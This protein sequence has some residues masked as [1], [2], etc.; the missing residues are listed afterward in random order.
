[1]KQNFGL[2]QAVAFKRQAYYWFTTGMPSFERLL[3][4]HEGRASDLDTKQVSPKEYPD[5]L[6]VRD[7]QQILNI[8][9]RQAY[10]LVNSGQFHVVKIGKRIKVSKKVFL[11]WLEGKQESQN[12]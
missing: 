5:V 2:P 10:E 7:I 8:G 4:F 1:M 9:R 11:Q 12:W 3:F 6:D